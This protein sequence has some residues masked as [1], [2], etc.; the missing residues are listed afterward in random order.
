MSK[1]YAVISDLHCHI[2][3]MFGS[4]GADGINT[5]LRSILDEVLRCAGTLKLAG[6]DTIVIAGDIFH[7]RGVLDPEVLNPVRSTFDALVRSG[8]K[9]HIIPGNHDLKSRNT[10]E[11]SSSVEN[12]SRKALDEFNPGFIRLYNEP[13]LLSKLSGQ[14][15]AAF[16]PWREN[17]KELL[18][19]IERLAK[20]LKPAERQLTDLFIHAGIQGILTGHVTADLTDDMLGKFGFRHVFAGHYH[21]HKPMKHNVFSVGATTH[22]TWSDVGTRAGYL[23]V[24]EDSG[25]VTFHDSKAPKFVDVSGSDADEMEL[26]CPDNFVRFRSTVPMLQSDINEL[27]RQFSLW[28]A[29]GVS[30]EVAPVSSVAPR[31]TAPTGGVSIP[32]SIGTFIDDA[33]IAAD[34]DKT[35]IKRRSLDTLAQSRVIS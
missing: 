14:V 22:Q 19:D 11:L 4:T 6:G 33:T 25:K 21:N 12:L 24:D 2:W 31:S 32:D 27:R 7:T 29:L 16:V 28:G 9:I 5:R 10:R 35:E 20:D 34:L 13:F 1:P 30:I 17:T 8:F 26:E 15:G 23:L 18:Q 3:T